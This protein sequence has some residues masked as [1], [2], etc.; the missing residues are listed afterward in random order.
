MAIK[1]GTV[2]VSKNCIR[3]NTLGY[4]FEAGREFIY[5][6]TYQGFYLVE[7]SIDGKAYDTH[8]PK[9][10]GDGGSVLLVNPC[11]VEV[12]GESKETEQ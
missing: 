7:R 8:L 3:C 1:E 12:K 10:S 9:Y 5:M 4:Q 2:L 6:G 11:D